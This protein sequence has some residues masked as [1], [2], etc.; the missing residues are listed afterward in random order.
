M[1][2]ASTVAALQAIGR[3]GGRRHRPG[4][5]PAAIAYF[6]WHPA[7]PGIIGQAVANVP[8]AARCCPPSLPQRQHLAG[9]GLAFQVCC[10]GAAWAILPTSAT[11]TELA[12]AGEWL[13][14]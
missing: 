14:R 11:A 1:L 5:C 12:L 8:H 4:A 13:H 10:A 3:P 7:A 6:G 9:A 2:A